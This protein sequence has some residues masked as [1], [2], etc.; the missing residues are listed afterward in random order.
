MDGVRQTYDGPV[1]FA[2]D[3]MVWNATKD[4]IRTRLGVHNPDSYPNPPLE[5]KQISES[6]DRYETAAWIMGALEPEVLPVIQRI[7]DDFNA[8]SG[9][10]I[11]NPLRK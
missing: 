7:Y 4:E 9:T 10:D 1:D 2:Q 3:F 5:E 11:P 6:G 8:E